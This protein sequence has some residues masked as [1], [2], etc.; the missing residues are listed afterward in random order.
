[1]AGA[2]HPQSLIACPSGEW[3]TQ[4]TS[5][6]P[7]SIRTQ[8]AASRTQDSAA[9]RILILIGGAKLGTVIGGV[10]LRK[11]IPVVAALIASRD[12]RSAPGHHI[13]YLGGVACRQGCPRAPGADVGGLLVRHWLEDSLPFERR[14]ALRKVPGRV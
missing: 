8:A 12:G 14:L 4:L 5:T 11:G 2:E 13:A 9:T 3:M 7:P 6:A 10:K 1:M